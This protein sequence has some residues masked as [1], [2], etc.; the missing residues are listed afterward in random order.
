[1]AENFDEKNPKLFLLKKIQSNE[2]ILKEMPPP[3]T[4]STWQ[5]VSQWDDDKDFSQMSQLEL[6]DATHKIIVQHF[7][8]ACTLARTL[9]RRCN[10]K[11][12]EKFIIQESIKEL[13]FI[14]NKKKLLLLLL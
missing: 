11:E 8:F 4:S 5:P 2:H 7:T 6:D 3:L 13:E 14:L 10:Q 9:S 12:L 1:M